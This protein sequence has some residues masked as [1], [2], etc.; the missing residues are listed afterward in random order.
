MPENYCSRCNTCM[1]KYG[2]EKTADLFPDDSRLAEGVKAL[3]ENQCY[4]G[5]NAGT[6]KQCPGLR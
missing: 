5:G 6:P 4:V 3:R 1:I 2:I